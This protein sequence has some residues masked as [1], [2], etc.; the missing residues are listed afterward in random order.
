MLLLL[1]L[2]SVLSSTNEAFSPLASFP[3][4]SNIK[5]VRHVPFAQ[6]ESTR[7]RNRSTRAVSSIVTKM[8][9]RQICEFEESDFALPSGEWPYTASDMGRI[10]SKDDANFYD[11]PRFVT[12]IDDPAIES[13]TKFYG[14]EILALSQ[15]KGSSKGKKKTRKKI[16]I[17]DLCSSWI[18]HL[19]NGTQY[20]IGM[21]VGIGMNEEELA[22][23]DQLYM[24][25]R[26]DLNKNATLAQF[27]DNSVDMVTCAVSVDY[28]TNPLQMFQ[29]IFRILRPGGTALIS[30]S[31]RC[32]SSKAIAM[33][34]QADDID[35]LTIVAS[36][37]HYAAKWRSIEALDLNSP[38]IDVPKRPSLVEMFNN[39]TVGFAWANTAS[40][41]NKSNNG[42]P[43]FV[44]K[45]IK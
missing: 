12:H 42:D 33:W 18:S 38:Q 36:Y 13:L 10:D 43:L 37:F 35:R 22:A 15:V 44:V 25:Y 2:V 4:T 24:Y 32:F 9:F 26:Q 39:P 6:P 27:E 11:A 41:V 23:N 19:P 14:E 45:A 1:L 34:L 21:V 40:A 20:P 7:Q 29:E 28:L 8:T 31:N 3:L 17:V 5:D 30:F 16:D